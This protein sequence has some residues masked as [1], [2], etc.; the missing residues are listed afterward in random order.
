MTKESMRLGQ[1]W[2]MKLGQKVMKKKINEKYLFKYR[3]N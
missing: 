3:N 1:V 2:G